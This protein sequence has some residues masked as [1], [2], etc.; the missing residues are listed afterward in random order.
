MEKIVV[1]GSSGHARV[2]VDVL[3]NEGRREI[4]GLLDRFRDA[5]EE[6]FG[7]PIL[8]REEDLPRLMET[9]SLAGGLVAIGDNFTRSEVERGIAPTVPGFRFFRAIHPGSCVAR[10][11]KI[12]DGTVVMAGAVVDPGCNLGRSCILNTNSSL[13]HDSRMGDY[14]SLAPGATTGGNVRIGDGA[15]IGIGAILVHDV[16]VGEQTVIGAASTVFQDIGY[17]KVAYGTPAKVIRYRGPA[18]RYL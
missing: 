14:A 4:V 8:G 10:D 11:A 7:Y 12:G 9:H 1:I 15:A 6:A 16:E 17:L 18:D 3:E 2:V 5:G 13:D